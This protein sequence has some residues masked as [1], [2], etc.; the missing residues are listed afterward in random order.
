MS[1]YPTPQHLRPILVVDEQR[2]G[3]EHLTGALRC[4]CGQDSFALEYVG[5]VFDGQGAESGPFLAGIGSEGQWFFRLTARCEGC[6][7]KHLLFDEHLHGWNGYVCSTDASRRAAKPPSK[8]WRCKCGNAAQRLEMVVSG[9][10]KTNS[11][12]E[13]GG[14]LNDDNWFEAFGWVTM[15]KTCSGCGAGP[16][17]IVDHETM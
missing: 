5:E 12:L 8:T 3:E 11:I 10:D 1:L 6:D 14:L 16:D 7:A 2:S 13:S 9:E 4:T 17:V 15:S